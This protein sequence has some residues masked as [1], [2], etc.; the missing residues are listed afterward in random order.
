L[1]RSYEK[2]G[3]FCDAVLAIEAWASLN[4]TRNDTSQT[5]A[6]IAD[7]TKRG[8]CEAT[9]GKEETFATMGR[10][11]VRLPVLVNGVPGNF[12]LDTGATFVSLKNA[13]AQ[14]AKLQA[15]Q[16]STIRLHTANGSPTASGVGP[17]RFKSGR[18]WPRMSRLWFKTMRRLPTVTG[19]MGCWE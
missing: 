18:F 8:Q 10:S 9:V 15:D 3:Q 7:Y 17:Q 13:Y 12:V 4:P 11:V 2:L 6:M 1:A 19:S 14:K 16:E 5:R